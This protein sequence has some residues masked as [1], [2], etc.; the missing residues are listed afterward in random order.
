MPDAKV[1]L[2]TEASSGSGVRVTHLVLDQAPVGVLV[3]PLW[4]VSSFPE[5]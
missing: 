1:L 3:I 4:P 5:Q 2:I